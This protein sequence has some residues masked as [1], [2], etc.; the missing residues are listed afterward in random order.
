MTQFFTKKFPLDEISFIKLSS[1]YE[2]SEE[3]LHTIKFFLLSF[4]Y[5]ILQ[6]I[7][8]IFSKFISDLFFEFSNKIL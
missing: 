5:V 6:S 8:T 4:L 7:K 3:T 2:S 1:I